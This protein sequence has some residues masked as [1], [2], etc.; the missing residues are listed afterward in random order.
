MY[1][2]KSGTQILVSDKNLSL[3]KHVMQHDRKFL[4][5]RLVDAKS[6]V[7]TGV[8]SM[9][10]WSVRD[11]LCVKMWVFSSG[12]ATWPYLIVETKDID[13]GKYDSPIDPPRPAKRVDVA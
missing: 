5:H 1:T 3:H 12:V 9:Q 6:L 11:L 8:D 10:P 13:G 7:F 2:I 4:S